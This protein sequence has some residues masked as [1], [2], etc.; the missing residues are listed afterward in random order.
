MN[1]EHAS[2][3]FDAASP[4]GKC[5]E[6]VSM[7]PLSLPDELL[8][9]TITILWGGRMLFQGLHACRGR[10]LAEVSGSIPAIGAGSMFEAARLL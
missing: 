9:G 6:S 8:Q 4:G 1:N 3:G 10:V 5:G 2:I 7:C